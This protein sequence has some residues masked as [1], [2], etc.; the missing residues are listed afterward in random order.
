MMFLDINLHPHGQLSV[1]GFCSRWLTLTIIEVR[2]SVKMN[3]K[4]ELSNSRVT[5][6]YS[7]NTLHCHVMFPIVKT[8]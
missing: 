8:L 7:L 2:V 1:S 6:E 4:R 3:F 5:G